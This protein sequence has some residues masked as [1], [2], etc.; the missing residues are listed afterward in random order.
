MLLT[1]DD[2][3][4]LL[5]LHPVYVRDVISKRKGFPDAIRI[6]KALRWKA[7][8]IEDWI[9]R[10]RVSPAVRARKAA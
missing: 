3:A 6:G 8:E 9:D 2:L 4:R 10:Q 1:A 5:G 7:D